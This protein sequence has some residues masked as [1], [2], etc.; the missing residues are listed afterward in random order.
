MNMFNSKIYLFIFFGMILLNGITTA[1]DDRTRSTKQ[2]RLE[3]KKLRLEEET[4]PAEFQTRDTP[5]TF[6]MDEIIIGESATTNEDD[7]ITALFSVD[8]GKLSYTPQHAESFHH[9]VPRNPFR[10]DTETENHI[11]LE[12]YTKWLVR[13]SD[14]HLIENLHFIAYSHTS[15]PIL[16]LPGSYFSFYDYVLLNVVT[17]DR[18]EVDFDNEPGRT[19]WASARIWSIN[20]DQIHLFLSKDGGSDWSIPASDLRFINQW[21]YYDSITIGT[22]E[23]IFSSWYPHILINNDRNEYV[24]ATRIK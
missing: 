23:G 14:R 9:L 18:I 15:D 8:V 5:E 1:D 12:N 16:I 11:I 19:F 4:N 22:N 24:R 3:I 21:H 7:I 20:F 2:E 13:P 6:G 10:S 17:G